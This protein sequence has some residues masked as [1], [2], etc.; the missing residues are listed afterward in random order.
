MN[1]ESIQLDKLNTVIY[2]LTSSLFLAITAL[3]QTTHDFKSTSPQSAN[4]YYILGFLRRRL[5]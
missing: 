4:T 5:N 1:E 3:Q 2:G